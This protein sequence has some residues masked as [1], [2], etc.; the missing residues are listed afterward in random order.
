[1][2]AFSHGRNINDVQ[3][4]GAQPQDELRSIARSATKA[5]V[6]ERAPEAIIADAAQRIRLALVHGQADDEAPLQLLRLADFLRAVPPQ[7]FVADDLLRRGWLYTLSGPTGHGKTGVAAVLALC[8]GTGKKF[9]GHETTRGRVVYVAGENPDD[10]RLRFL[11][12]ADAMGIDAAAAD[13]QVLDRSLILADRMP[14]MLALLNEAQPSLLIVDTDQAVSLD[15]DVEENANSTR[16]AHAKRLRALTR[17][18]SR[19]TVVDLCHPRAGATRESLVP[20]GGSSLLAEV[21]GN[22]CLWRDG[23]VV[24][25]FTDGAKF[26][27][28]PASVTFQKVMRT[29][30]AAR[31]TK[32]RDMS[33]PYFEAMG[34][35]QA[36]VLRRQ[37]W[38]DGN[39][40]LMAML[41]EPRGSQS[42]WA[43]TAGFI[44]RDGEARK[45]KVNRLLRALERDG[46]AKQSRGGY[47]NLTPAGK[48]EAVKP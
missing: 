6:M 12:T 26:R 14:E 24:E 33:I 40:V 37:A 3:P 25:L 4:Q 18:S 31:D 28:T 20:R 48:K 32:G 38:T 30:P 8:V 15:G 13:V 34:D 42:D 46:L 45:D 1:M 44:G 22:L 47:W 7:E 27:G 41:Q 35:A 36:Q 23:D 10:V 2:I 17:V 21:D 9:A 29:H 39:L 5:S 43:R 11:I 19:P 16:M